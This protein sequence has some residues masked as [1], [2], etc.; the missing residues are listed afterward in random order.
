MAGTQQYPAGNWPANSP[1]PGL[2]P[3]PWTVSG[4]GFPD[5]RRRRRRIVLAVVIATAVVVAIVVAGI[6]A[7]SHPKGKLVLPAT[8]LGLSKATSASATHLAGQIK[9]EEKAGSD[10]K[11][12]D[13]VAGVYGSPVGPQVIVTGGGI[14]GTCSAKSAAT[15]RSRLVAAGYPNARSFPAGANGGVLAC[16]SRS[17]QGSTVLRCAWVDDRTAGNVLFGGGVATSLADAAAKTK[18]VLAAAEH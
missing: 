9:A 2:E 4:A 11:L 12:S 13:V 14:C 3:S 6:V 17:S 1:G 16:G 5:R 7:A 15:Q 18:Q 8:L 10:G